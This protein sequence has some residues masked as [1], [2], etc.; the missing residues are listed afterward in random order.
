[1][2]YEE[3]I[4]MIKLRQE[5]EE[6]KCENATLKSRTKRWLNSE[7]VKIIQEEITLLHSINMAYSIKPYKLTEKE[8]EIVNA[9]IRGIIC[10]ENQI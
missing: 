9:N 8:I 3:N 2:N 7:Y 6:L 4:A 10:L 1:M 5:N